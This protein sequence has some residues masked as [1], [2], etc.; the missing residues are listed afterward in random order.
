MLQQEVDD[1]RVQEGHH[2][3]RASP[4]G[5][6]HESIAGKHEQPGRPRRIGS[7]PVRLLKNGLRRGI[8]SLVCVKT[9]GPKAHG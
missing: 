9:I 5:M 2:G 7:N 1:E 3:P 4:K 8:D 6:T